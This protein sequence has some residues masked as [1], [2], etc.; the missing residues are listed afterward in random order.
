MES[1]R[2]LSSF[3]ATGGSHLGVI[4]DSDTPSVLLMSSLLCNLMLVAVTAENCASQR[5]DIGNGSGIFSTFVVI[6]GYSALTLIQKVWRF[7]AISKMHVA[8]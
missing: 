2:A 7:E 5:W 1:V 4:G 3:P 8:C 6:S